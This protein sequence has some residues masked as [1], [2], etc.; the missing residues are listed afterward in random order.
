MRLTIQAV[1][2]LKST[3]KSEQKT[4]ALKVEQF[5]KSPV[6]VDAFTTLEEAR[7]SFNHIMCSPIYI[8][9]MFDYELPL[10]AQRDVVPVN[11]RLVEQLAKW[12]TAFEKYVRSSNSKLTDTE[13]RGTV[14]LK[15]QHIA[16][17]ITAYAIRSAIED[18][19]PLVYTLADR[20]TFVPFIDD[21]AML[22]KLAS[23]LVAAS[24]ADFESG[25]SKSHSY[26]S[27]DWGLVWP[28]HYS[29][30]KCPDKAIRAAALDV[31]QQCRRR[32]GMWDSE[33][34]VNLVQEASLVTPEDGSGSRQSTKQDGESLTRSSLPMLFDRHG[35]G[36]EWRWFEKGEGLH[37]VRI[38]DE[39]SR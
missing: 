5:T 30:I 39:I 17:T 11:N 24:K 35:I 21:F 33:A 27:V 36:G 3:P 9:L 37:V 12:S 15:I 29:Y 20:E 2:H 1:L 23:S 28:L 6:N 32:E 10:S 7:L 4:F 34:I 16:A 19:R 26:F 13:L 14:L 22:V 18:L 25:R 8:S 31:L 38:C